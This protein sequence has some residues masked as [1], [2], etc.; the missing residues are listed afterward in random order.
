[1]AANH[2]LNQCWFIISK[3]MWHS[4]ASI[5]IRISEDNN[6]Y[7]EIR[8]SILEHVTLVTIIETIILLPY[9]QVMSLQLKF[10]DCLPEI[11][12]TGA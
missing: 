4:S 5:I 3:D 2:Y 12:S 1:M 6:Q 10:E 9:F 8:N 11:S 7:S